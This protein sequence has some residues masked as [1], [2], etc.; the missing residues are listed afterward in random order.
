MATNVQRV[1]IAVIGYGAGLS[2]PSN[3]TDTDDT[4]RSIWICGAPATSSC[5]NLSGFCSAFVLSGIIVNKQ[6]LVAR[7]HAINEVAN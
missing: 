7:F 3:A 2:R 1:L 5:A 4:G 6:R